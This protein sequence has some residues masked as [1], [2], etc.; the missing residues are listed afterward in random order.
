[1]QQ[2]G[3]FYFSASNK[4]HRFGMS[5]DGCPMEGNI[6]WSNESVNVRKT[7]KIQVK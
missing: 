4:Y 3:F 6:D 7:T 1:M 2:W 5:G